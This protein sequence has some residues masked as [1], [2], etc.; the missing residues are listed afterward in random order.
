MSAIIEAKGNKV[1]LTDEEYRLLSDEIIRDTINFWD[2]V[3][4]DVEAGML[5]PELSGNVQ[6]IDR[7]VLNSLRSKLM[8]VFDL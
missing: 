7:K 5:P 3:A 6:S 4:R 2:S 1:T 8:K